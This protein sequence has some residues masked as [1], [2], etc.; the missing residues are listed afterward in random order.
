MLA[1]GYMVTFGTRAGFTFTRFN[2]K[3]SGNK[4]TERFA[5]TYMS[6]FLIFQST[7]VTACANNG[8]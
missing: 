8:K 5:T 2:L 4:I 6:P 3:F 1:S 7:Y